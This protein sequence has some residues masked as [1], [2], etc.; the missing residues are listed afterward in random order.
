MVNYKES[1]I[2]RN[3]SIYSNIGPNGIYAISLLNLNG[4]HNLSLCI[5]LIIYIDSTGINDE[6]AT[7]L[8]TMFLEDLKCINLY[9]NSITEMTIG[10]IFNRKFNNL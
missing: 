9:K 5:I 2:T 7:Y 6:G 1:F 4:L 8:A 10:N 3:I